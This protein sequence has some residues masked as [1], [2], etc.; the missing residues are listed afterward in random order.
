MKKLISTLLT[1][2]MLLSLIPAAFAA[3]TTTLEKSGVKIVYDISGLMKTRNMPGEPTK[4]SM[5]VITYEETDGFYS[6]VKGTD[7]THYE[8]NGT[9]DG[10]SLVYTQSGDSS[11]IDYLGIGGDAKLSFEFV[12]PKA[13]LYDLEINYALSNNGELKNT[14]VNVYLDLE[15]NQITT[16]SSA[17]RGSYICYDENVSVLTATTPYVIKDLEFS[18]A[19]KYTITFTTNTNRWHRNTIG[20]FVLNGGDD[21]VPMMST[22]EIADD[23]LAVGENAQITAEAKKLSDGSDATGVTYSYASAENNIAE[24]DENGKVTANAVGN[25][26]ITVTASCNGQSASK[27]IPVSVIPD[28]AA[29]INLTYNFSSLMIGWKETNPGF[30]KLTYDATYDL[31]NYFANSEGHLGHHSDNEY[32]K[33]NQTDTSG[34]KRGLQI[35]KREAWYAATIQVP[36][37]GS[38]IASVDYA[39]HS[40]NT[41][42]LAVYLFEKNADLSIEEITAQLTPAN[43]LN[44]VYQKDTNA[45]ITWQDE[46]AILGVEQIESGEYYLVFRQETEGAYAWFGDFYLNGYGDGVAPIIPDCTV[47]KT[48]LEEGETV[49]VITSEVRYLT[50][51]N[52]ASNV[53]YTYESSDNNVAEVEN[54]KITAKNGGNATITVSA[55]ADGATLPGTRTIDLTVTAPT[56]LPSEEEI[57][58]VTVKFKASAYAGGNVSN[59]NVQDVTIGDDVTVTATAN[60]G[61]TFAYWKNSAGVVLSTS[62]TETFKVNTNMGVIAVFD[63]EA[64]DTAI[65]VQFYNG[66]GMPLGSTSVAKDTTF[67]AAKTA[68]GVLTIP[69]LTGFVFSHWSDKDAEVA[70]ADGDLITALTR[71]VAIYKDDETKTYTVKNGDATVASGKKYGDSVTLNG[72]D[73]FKAWKLGDKVMSYEKDFTFNVYGNI[74]LTE[75]TD[76]TMEKAPV[77][78]LDKVGGNYFLTYDSGTYELIEAGILFAKTGKPEIGSYNSKAIA[79]KGTGQ[80]TAQPSTDNEPIARGYMICKSGDDYKVIYAD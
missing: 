77:L 24:V 52:E 56:V 76:E 53:A 13:G 10:G 7:G 30:A 43:L 68:A 67:G 72:S 19:G 71:A 31:N 9:Y 78:V 2:A 61:Y 37:S 79:V 70:I 15:N 38:Y 1:I 41:G 60:D 64:T 47:A 35:A 44:R 75:V 74:T 57:K 33:G 21:L 11:K 17:L 3:E 50:D 6:F 5:T 40:S 8:N 54:G 42:Y 14:A 25:T 22:C 80:F 4:T 73:N 18:K 29:G 36:V 12:V 34:K 23:T 65:P 69:T 59:S 48:T 46:P 45:N 39:K 20:T 66:N 51:G 27:V 32:F 28:G 16:N 62:A 49:D 58:D 55:T 63:A 26:E